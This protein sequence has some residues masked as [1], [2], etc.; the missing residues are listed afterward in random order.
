MALPRRTPTWIW[1]GRGV[2]IAGFAGVTAYLVRVGLA[3]ADLVS[4][5]LGALASLVGLVLPYLLPPRA[6]A[7]PPP[8]DVR[9]E[10]VGTG[11][12]E[13]GDGGRA[14]SGVGGSSARPATARDTGDAVARGDGSS[15]ISGVE[16]D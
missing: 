5:S 14:V 13:A 10:A 1:I 11:R 16:R 8:V 6:P 7:S 12:A 3:Q 9:D 15:A 4:S 2:A